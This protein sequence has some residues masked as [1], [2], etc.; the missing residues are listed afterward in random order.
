MPDVS[1]YFM[2][3]IVTILVISIWVPAQSQIS[4]SIVAARYQQFLVDTGNYMTPTTFIDI[5]GSTKTLADFKGKILYVSMWATT[6]EN[7]IAEFPYLEQLL[8]RL[9]S[10]HIDSFFQF[11]NIHV[12]DRQKQWQKSLK[13]HNPIGINLY[14]S[15]TSLL[16]KWNLE[17]P[18]AYILLDP[19]GRLLGKD[20]FWPVEAGSIDYILY[21]ATKGIYPADAML[22]KHQQDKLMAQHKTSAAITDEGY[23]TWFNM[24]IKSFLE[25]QS[26]R[27][28]HTKKNSR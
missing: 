11:I 1:G 5:H 23:A 10:I 27:T 22:K 26:W 13:K 16:A 17:G 18:P 14:S 8:K 21:S 3:A 12:E 6:C 2:R 19:S 25:F 20:I 4:D 9:Q 24:T 28:E 7:S 15:D